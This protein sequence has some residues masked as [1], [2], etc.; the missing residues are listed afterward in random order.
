MDSPQATIIFPSQQSTSIVSITV[1]LPHSHFCSQLLSP[2]PNSF[3]FLPCPT[4]T[5]TH[6]LSHS[7]LEILP[8]TPMTTITTKSS[9]HFYNLILLDLPGAS[10]MASIFEV[11]FSLTLKHKSLLFSHLYWAPSQCPAPPPLPSFVSSLSMALSPLLMAHT[12]L[13][14]IWP[15]LLEEIERM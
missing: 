14:L 2:L 1:L 3:T 4:H 11:S 7:A 6:S 15:C 12:L 9:L 13:E 10:H 5:H 8:A